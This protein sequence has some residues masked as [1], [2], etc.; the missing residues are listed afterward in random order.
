MVVS[1]G[2]TTFMVFFQLCFF[3]TQKHA[4]ALVDL[5][6]LVA[7]SAYLFDDV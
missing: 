5:N 7:L 1:C 6:A 2:T 3:D 4:E